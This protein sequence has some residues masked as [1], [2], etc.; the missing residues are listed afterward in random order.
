MEVSRGSRDKDGP[1]S[2]QACNL[3]DN[4]T[5]GYAQDEAPTWVSMWVAQLRAPEQVGNFDRASTLSTSTCAASELM[6]VHFLIG[7]PGA[8]CVCHSTLE[9]RPGSVV[10]PKVGLSTIFTS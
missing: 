3:C 1:A 5:S 7:G 6:V 10:Q 8:A 9:T 4:T 2:P